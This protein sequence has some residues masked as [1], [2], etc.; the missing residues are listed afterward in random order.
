MI[1][2]KHLIESVDDILSKLRKEKNDFV[3]QWLVEKDPDYKE[4]LEKFIFDLS[5]EIEQLKKKS[6]RELDKDEFFNHHYTGGI[7]DDAYKRNETEGGLKWLGDKSKYPMLIDTSKHGNFTVEFRQRDEENKYVK[8]DNDGN[9]LRYS[10]GDPVYL[11]RDEMIAEKLSLR[12]QTIVAFVDD[13]PIGL[14][15]NEFGTVGVW[16]EKPYQ[17]FGIG[18][19][20]ME[21]HIEQRPDIKS[22][23]NKI[24]QMTSAGKRLTRKYYDKMEKKHGNGWWKSG[25]KPITES[26]KEYRKDWME[27]HNA[28]LDNIGRL[29]AY[30]GTPTRNLKSIQQNGFKPHSYFSLKPNYSKS[31]SATYHNTTEDNVIVIEVHLPLNLIDFVASD[32]YS[33]NNIPFKDTQ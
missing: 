5:K 2:L 26:T 28:K 12:D 7:P 24:G 9:I 32:I 1:K 3:D 29:I 19:D 10:N 31:I 17:G 14:A 22:G 20:L 13:K 23:R 21:K 16:V 8:H 33:L 30:H 6:P 11:T 15:S 4:K 25:M 18:T 27:R